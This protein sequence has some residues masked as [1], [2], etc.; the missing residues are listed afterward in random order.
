[1]SAEA[2]A[3]L[4]TDFINQLFDLVN[5]PHAHEKLGAILAIEE[6]IEGSKNAGGSAESTQGVNLANYLRLCFKQINDAPVL[7]AASRALGKL[8][9]T[10]G[11]TL[12]LETVEAMTVA[13]LD[14]LGTR[15]QV[16]PRR[17]AGVLVLKELSQNTRAVI[18]T[19]VTSL[20]DKIWAALRDKDAKIRQPAVETLTSA[21]VLISERDSRYR[22]YKKL[23]E[24][25]TK[26][27]EGVSVEHLHG[28]LLVLGEL[29]VAAHD[30]MQ[31]R[32]REASDLV[33]RYKDSK[34][35]IIKRTV[36]MLLPRF[37]ATSP[38]VFVHAYLER[39]MRYLLECLSKR[40]DLR[41]LCYTSA[42]EI[43]KNMGGFVYKLGPYLNQLIDAIK[44]GLMI[45]GKGKE[46]AGSFC[47]EAL[48]CICMLA[49]ALGNVLRTPMADIIPLMF[50]AGL[51]EQLAEALQVLSRTFPKLHPIIQERLLEHLSQVLTG[52]PYLKAI[53][54]HSTGGV[55]VNHK[56]ISANTPPALIAL[57]L[58]TLGSFNFSGQNISDFLRDHVVPYL[59]D[60]H[61]SVRREAALTCAAFIGKAGEGEGGARVPS[62]AALIA[63]VLEK[64]LLQMIS[65]PDPGVRRVLGQIDPRFDALLAEVCD[66][67]KFC[68]FF[69]PSNNHLI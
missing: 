35:R 38:D 23:Y 56:T 34:E 37:V 20:F 21:L 59:D 45:R 11:G 69:L 27:L 10:Y 48:T 44:D 17:L 62:T 4:E 58:H 19:H 6:I 49:Q 66:V 32:F 24:E 8:V 36:I 30:F 57:A 54:S 55:Q 9:R 29:L 47:E 1:M 53:S 67:L 22:Y 43:A 5:S 60:E 65:D 14:W 41:P 68:F 16:E 33:L 26:G 25:A 28:S 61:A 63:E 51:T 40:D 64:L 13:A 12:T 18:F 15:G 31:D 50:N 46:A 7:Y 42:G 52:L 39:S 3:K 2:Y